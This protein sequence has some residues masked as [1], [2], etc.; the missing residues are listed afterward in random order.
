MDKNFS[1]DEALQ[2]SIK[3]FNGDSLAAK[4]FVDKYSLRDNNDNI[5][6]DSP[7]KMHWRIANE[8]G[9]IESKKFKKECFPE[10]CSNP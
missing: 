5:L 7:E 2:T 8:L 10:S 1:Y 6:E 3:Y 9:R 4:V